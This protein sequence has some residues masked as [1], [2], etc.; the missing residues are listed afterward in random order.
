MMTRLYNSMK[1]DFQGRF[2][3]KFSVLDLKKHLVNSILLRMLTVGFHHQL[4]GGLCIFWKYYCMI[5]AQFFYM[6]ICWEI[7][8]F[9]KTLINSIFRNHYFDYNFA[10]KSLN[11]FLK[12]KIYLVIIENLG[13]DWILWTLIISNFDFFR[14]FKYHG[15]RF[16]KW[17]N[18]FIF[19]IYFWI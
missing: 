16:K 10:K 3:N 19:I 15:L 7:F 2:D 4:C 9:L 6:T 14:F 1:F 18:S 17:I 5:R 8:I 11:S 13:N 12:T